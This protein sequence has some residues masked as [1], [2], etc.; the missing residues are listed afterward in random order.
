MA[1]K[2]HEI[3]DPLHVFIKFDSGERRVID[4]TPVQRLRHIHQLA[5]SYLVYPGATHRRFEHSLGVMELAGR[6]YD[7]VSRPDN[8]YHEVVREFVPQQQGYEYQY[9]R[10]VL[11]LAALCHDLGHL[12][13]SHAAEKELLPDGWD[14]ERL[15]IEIIRSDE[16]APLWNNLKVEP[17]DIAKLAVGPAKYPDSLNPWESILS[18]IICGDAFGVDRMDYLLRDSKHTGVPYGGFDHYRLIDTLRILP[19]PG[20]SDEPELGVE[21][22]G[23]QSAE[24]LLWARYFMYTQV[25]FHPI[26]RIYDIHLKDFLT[27]WLQ[28]GHFPTDIDK[29]LEITDN[30]V[31][32]AM[33]KSSADS[34]SPQHDAAR[35]IIGREHFRLL[36]QRNPDDL[37]KNIEC[38]DLIFEAVKKEFGPERVRRDS[39]SQKGRGIDFPVYTRDGRIVSS[40][41]M[42]ET[43]KKIPVFAVDYVFIEPSARQDALRWLGQNRDTIIKTREEE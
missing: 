34:N 9:W 7:V 43:L 13:F 6:V 11:R 40:V 8:I 18:E 29:L 19:K 36:Y 5:M 17:E 27:A 3:R 15:T 4:S 26:R 28:G 1:N 21:E 16:M 24:A 33:L 22:G 42:S 23:L 31:T 10:L 32:T 14:H 41:S 38:V 25:Y 12:P 2:F 35:R 20:E 39:Y 30:E 37:A